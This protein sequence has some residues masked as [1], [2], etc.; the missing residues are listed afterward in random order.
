MVRL[1][2][3]LSG[4]ENNV[5][6][7]KAAA[8]YL[9]IIGHAFAFACNYE[10]VD[11]MSVL[12]GG[13]YNL[14]GFA[15]GIFFF[16]SGLFITK[17]LMAGKYTCGSFFKRRI[18]RIFPPLIFV[19]AAIIIICGLFFTDMNAMAY[20]TD[21]RTYKYLLNCIFISVHELPGVFGKNISGAAV[22]GPIWTIKFEFACY[23]MCYVLYRL[24]LI[25]KKRFQF[26]IYFFII[27]AI[28]IMYSDGVISGLAVLVRPVGMFL[29]GMA[30]TVYGEYVNLNIM[31]FLTSVFIY[32][33]FLFFGF[34]ET[35]LFFTMPY[36]V[37]CMAFLYTEKISCRAVQEI[38]KASYE[39]YLWGGF[40]GQA[41]TY[42]FGGRMSPWLNMVI[43]IIV[44]T[45]AGLFTNR[46]MMLRKG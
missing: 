9:V 25:T 22:N 42:V 8:A 46:I 38:G 44:S 19:T 41:V 6:F 45:A 39:I 40:V 14:G 27:A 20:F 18:I 43:T 29:L 37:C 4:K 11:I 13:A 7:I 26:I 36:M 1:S 28:A 10:Q 12:S 35:G 31:G 23:V 33:L 21:T 17:S 15:V 24:R 2:D 30:Y 5:Y 34:P 3:A 16:F 32:G